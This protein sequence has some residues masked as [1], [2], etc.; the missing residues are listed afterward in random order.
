MHSMWL[1]GKTAGFSTGMYLLFVSLILSAVMIQVDPDPTLHWNIR[2]YKGL[3]LLMYKNKR[4]ATLERMASGLNWQ[5]KKIQSKNNERNIV[6]VI[7][8][9]M[10]ITLMPITLM[11]ITLVS[12]GFI[13]ASMVY[14]SKNDAGYVLSTLSAIFFFASVLSLVFLFNVYPKLLVADKYSIDGLYSRA[15]LIWYAL[16]HLMI[17]VTVVGKTFFQLP[18]PVE[19]RG[20][21]FILVGLVLP[22]LVI[23]MVMRIFITC[24]RKKYIEWKHEEEKMKDNDEKVKNK[25]APILFRSAVK[26]IENYEKRIEELKRDLDDQK[27]NNSKFGLWVDKITKQRPVAIIINRFPFHLQR[28]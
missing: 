15:M 24:Q 23:I 2:I 7:F 28:R 6:R 26:T 20:K 10:S 11:S 12:I 17:L 4:K 25:K 3:K 21:I 13:Y 27:R 22:S 5:P 14:A 8:I 16:S 18:D 19:V 1:G 9:L